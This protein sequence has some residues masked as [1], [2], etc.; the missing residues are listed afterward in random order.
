MIANVYKGPDGL[1]DSRCTCFSILAFR[2]VRVIRG[3]K[4]GFPLPRSHMQAFAAP[5]QP[6]VSPRILGLRFAAVYPSTRINPKRIKIFKMRPGLGFA[7]VLCGL[8]GYFRVF[9]GPS[10]T[11]DPTIPEF[12]SSSRSTYRKRAFPVGFSGFW[13]VLVGPLGR[14]L[15]I[16]AV[17]RA[18]SVF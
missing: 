12:Q 14:F 11:S 18:S 1:T 7:R 3:L 17:G 5:A 8:L 4:S 2:V 16:I 6:P 10:C 15:P 9:R 13:W